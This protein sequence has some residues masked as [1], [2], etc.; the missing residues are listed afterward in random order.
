MKIFPFCLL[1]LFICSSCAPDSE[2]TR[3]RFS[4]QAARE[5]RM[6]ARDLG[7]TVGLL[8]TGPQNAITDVGEVRVGHKTVSK[9]TDIRTGVTAILPHAKNLYQ[10][11]VPAAVYCYNAYGKLAGSTQIEELGNIETPIVLTNTLNVGT[12]VAAVVKHS[13]Q[14]AGNE[15]VQSVNAVVGETN[16]GYLNDIRGQYVSETD[17][18]DAINSASNDLPAEGSVGAGTGTVAFRYKG[19]IGTS[20]RRI[21]PIE[22]ISYTVGVLLQSN[23][24]MELSILGVPFTRE[25]RQEDL[26]AA[27]DPEE[28]GSCMI[29]IATDAP[30]SPRNL[31]RMAKRAFAG[32]AR[33]RA[34]MTNSSGDYAI[35]FST[36]YTISGNPDRATIDVQALLK[37]SEMNVIFRAVEEAT[38]E[39][40][41]NSLFMATTVSG[42]QGHTVPAIPL[43]EVNRVLEKYNRLELRNNLNWT[44]Y[45]YDQ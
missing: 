9:G 8:K 35:A 19:G 16:D 20:S 33:T 11:K 22:N 24:G 12:A 37:N 45:S 41:Y 2:S 27:A 39:A 34:M 13:L 30:V 1:A 3:D 17:V 4:T 14:Q 32:M 31:K 23:F 36:A 26:K 25:M 29:I 5:G 15:N 7:V 42:Y 21:P 44:P 38:E 40:I 28:D 43:D 18:W 6:R 10:F